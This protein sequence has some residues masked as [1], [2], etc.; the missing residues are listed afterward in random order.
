ML[1]LTGTRQKAEVAPDQAFRERALPMGG[2]APIREIKGRMGRVSA[3]TVWLTSEPSCQ[4]PA[5]GKGILCYPRL[6]HSVCCRHS[7]GRRRPWAAP[8]AALLSEMSRSDPRAPGQPGPAC[9]TGS[10]L[11]VGLNQD[12]NTHM[13][14]QQSRNSAGAADVD[15]ATAH[16]PQPKPPHFRCPIPVS[17]IT[18]RACLCIL[19]ALPLDCQ[20]ALEFGRQRPSQQLHALFQVSSAPPCQRWLDRRSGCTPHPAGRGTASHLACTP[21]P[22]A[23]K[24][25]QRSDAR[26]SRHAPLWSLRVHVSLPPRRCQAAVVASCT[27]E[28]CLPQLTD[29]AL[30]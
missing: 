19:H 15:A 24:H 11:H 1:P 20:A 5:Y 7:Q 10:R 14:V 12:N 3:S 28:R 21:Q 25:R 17:T 22:G 4:H 23:P 30:P 27:Y 16:A 8:P 13:G 9:G 18:E 2:A 6:I 26:D 29:N